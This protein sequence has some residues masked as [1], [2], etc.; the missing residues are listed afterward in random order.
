MSLLLNWD[1]FIFFVTKGSIHTNILSTVTLQF[2]LWSGSNEDTDVSSQGGDKPKQGGEKDS[3]HNFQ[4][5]EHK[6]IAECYISLT[7]LLKDD[8]Y[9]VKLKKKKN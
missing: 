3:E 1:F 4:V 9:S 5:V 2:L 8:F 7:K 6:L